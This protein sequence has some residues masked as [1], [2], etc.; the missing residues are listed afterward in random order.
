MQAFREWIEA[1]YGTAEALNAAWT[2][3]YGAF[4]DIVAPMTIDEAAEQTESF[5]PWVDFRLFMDTA[6]ADAHDSIAEALR[7]VDPG[8]KVGWDGLLSYHWL[9]GYDFH[10]LS[11]N[12]E[13]NQVYT[14]GW[15]QDEF[16][17]SFARPDAF[18]GQWGNSIA[19]NEEGFAA[20]PWHNIFSGHNS[21]W[22]WTSWGCDYIPF[23]PD[24]STSKFGEWHFTGADEVRSGPG[25]LLV[26]A[27]R[28]NSGIAVLYNQADMFAAKLA[29]KL[30][31]GQPYAGDRAWLDNHKGLLRAIQDLGLQFDYVA[32]TELHQHGA[33]ALDGYRALFLP[34]ATCLSDEHIAAIEAFAQAGG[35]VVADARAGILTGSGSIRDDR[36]F[37]D[38]FGVQSGSGLAAFTASM[39]GAEDAPELTTNTIGRGRAHLMNRPFRDY[40]G[41]RH[42]EDRDAYLARLAAALPEAGFPRPCGLT[43]EGTLPKCVE[44]VLLTDGNLR[45]LCLEQDILIRG[46]AAQVCTL[47]LPEPSIVY[48][49]R[50]GKQVGDGP[51]SEWEVEVSRGTP[52]VLALLPYEVTGLAA[53]APGAAKLGEV[54]DVETQVAVSEGQPGRHVVYMSVYA[55][56]EDRPHRQYSQSIECPGG[57]GSARIPFAL[58]DPTGEWRLVFKDTASGATTE[59]VVSVAR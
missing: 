58:T 13:L 25:K 2:S 8:A 14:S 59:K 33:D 57:T 49:L 42:T 29:D 22:W 15:P 6:F 56:Q 23:N 27:R 20:V 11:R 21:C 36:P 38:L 53:E 37:D 28:E 41:V 16:V 4:A 1:Q 35:V 46:L 18:T 50:A 54:L 3:E 30:S 26:N 44:Q 51:V 17:R 40:G 43:C 10:K 34:L 12:L 7:E 47:T 52:L 39:P 48:D 55:P 9:A 31:P 32:A 45:Y 19:D 24:L 5:A